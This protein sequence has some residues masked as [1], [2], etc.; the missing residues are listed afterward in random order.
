MPDTCPSCSR[1]AEGASFCPHCGTALGGQSQCAACDASLPEGASF[2]NQCG[3][4]AGSSPVQK[5]ST[6]AGPGRRESN[7]PWIVAGL[8]LV[9][10]IA[11]LVFP[12]LFP[13][14]PASTVVAPVSG[15]AASIDLSSMT[16]RQAA[17]RLFNRVMSSVAAGDSAQART[18]L[19]MAIGAYARVQGLDLDGRY[20]L[21]VLLSLI[22]I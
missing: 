17:D 9:G 8:A 18:F 5:A 16:P 7:L 4:P 13:D 21:A 11:V 14:E 15:G 6:P 10:L 1:P 20:H 22:H 2:C 12:R 3:T 19:P